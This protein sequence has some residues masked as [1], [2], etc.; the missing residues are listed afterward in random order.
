MG[1]V[2]VAALYGAL[3][4]GVLPFPGGY[5]VGFGSKGSLVRCSCVG[6]LLLTAHACA[7]AGLLASVFAGGPGADS[8]AAFLAPFSGGLQTFGSSALFLGLLILASP[9]VSGEGRWVAY[10]LIFT[11]VLA[12]GV[13]VGNLVPGMGATANAA[14]V[15]GYLFALDLTTWGAAVLGGNLWLAIFAASAGAFGGA[16]YAHAHPELVASVWGAAD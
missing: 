3:G 10:A 16:L 11:F 5:A 4:F 14:Y 15:F 12:A 2:A 6:A 9:F 8:A 7:R 13:A 1:F